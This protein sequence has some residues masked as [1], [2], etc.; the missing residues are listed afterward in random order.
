LARVSIALGA[1]LALYARWPVIHLPTL[2]VPLALMLML[3]EMALGTAIGMLVNFLSEAFAVGAQTVALQAGYAYASVIDPS[4]QANSDVLM[5]MAQLLAGLLFFTA[6]LHIWVMRVFAD[7]LDRYPPGSFL[8]TQNIALEIVRV[9]ADVF[10]IGLRLSLPVVILLLLTEVTL[11]LVGRVSTQLHSGAH[12][13]PLKMMLT[14]TTLSLVLVITPS[15]YRAYADEIMRTLQ[16][17]LFP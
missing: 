17:A 14:L 13:V 5:V 15:L 9:G 1:T 2:T 7:S 11:A 16:R 8:L 10:T 3:S 6:N 4:T 12:S